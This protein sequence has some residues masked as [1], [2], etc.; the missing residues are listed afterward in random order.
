MNF[1]EYV[2]LQKIP[3]D[4]I[5]S[6]EHIKNKPNKTVVK[7][8][9]FQTFHVNDELKKFLESI[10][11][12][13]IWCQYQI[14]FSD[15]VIHKDKGRKLCYNYLIDQ[16]GSKVFTNFY[17]NEKNLIHSTNINLHEWAKINTSVF[18]NV[19]GVSNNCTRVA[20][21]VTPKSCYIPL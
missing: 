2:N 12:F 5:E 17:N 19:T 4:L 8:P 9:F 3:R 7:D 1:I 11:P 6:T 20:V 15:I 21:S 16:G 14:I 13:E 18:H 10:F